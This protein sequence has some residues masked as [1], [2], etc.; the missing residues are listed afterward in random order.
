V[1]RVDL[2]RHGA[3]EASA[4]TGKTFAIEGLVI[5]LLVQEGVHLE[6]ILV[7]TY[8]EK[9]AGDLKSRLRARLETELENLPLHA[10]RLQDALDHF[11]HAHV[12]TIHGFCQ[13]T[14][15]E[16]AFEN[17]HD[18]R[19]QL[20]NDREL[21]EL[22]LR[23]IQRKE[24]QSEHGA[25]LGRVLELSG[26][27]AGKR[28]AQ[29][30]EELVLKLAGDFR[31][32]CDHEIAPAELDHWPDRL[33]QLENA[34]CRLWNELRRLAGPIDPRAIEEHLWYLGYSEL[35]FNVSWRES[36]R[37]DLLVPLLTWLG[38]AD[39][40]QN[41]LSTLEELLH[42]TD[43]FRKLVD[44]RN[45]FG[46]A[47]LPHKCPNLCEAVELIET[48]RSSSDWAT[49]RKQLHVA[50]VHLL[51][52][53]LAEYKHERGLQS[54]EDM[55]TKLDEA[56][57]PA[58][59]PHADE[60]VAGLR[61]RYRYGIVD[62]FQDTDPVQWRIFRRIFV[63]GADRQRLFVV[64][65]PKQA[66]FAF[67]GAD[68]EAYRVAHGELL[69]RGAQAQ[70]LEVNW[71]SCPE[72]I[73]PLN[74]LFSH[75]NW[76]TSSGIPYRKVKAAGAEAPF[77]LLQGQARRP[78]TLVELGRLRTLGQARREYARYVV[79]EI[80]RLLHPPLLEFERKKQRRVLQAGDICLLVFKRREA[81]P[82]VDA[83]RE[84]GISFTLYKQ[85]GLWQSTEATHLGYV[86]RAVAHPDDSAAFRAALLTRFF[87][88][89]PAEL[90]VAGELPPNH[91]IQELFQKW[92]GLA[93]A[94]A[95]AELFQSILEET[96]VLFRE[97]AGTD[98][99]RALANYRQLA[100][101]L[102]K[103]AYERDLDLLGIL[104]VF[105]NL[106][107]QRKE[108]EADLQPLESERP[109]VKIMT[110]HASKGLEFP[111]VFLAGGF[112]GAMAPQYYTYHD[113]HKKVVFDLRL[114]DDTAKQRYA[115]ERD[116]EN[117]RLLYV[118]LTRA[119]FRLYLPLVSMEKR[120]GSSRGPL[121]E[122]LAPAVQQAKL[123]E[124]AGVRKIIPRSLRRRPTITSVEAEPANHEAGPEEIVQV[125][126]DLFPTLDP[127]LSRRRILI[128]SFSSLH[129]QLAARHAAE[130]SYVERVPRADDDLRASIAT[131]EP[132]RGP[133][134]GDMVH[135][136][137]AE[138][139][140][141][142]VG[143]ALV[144]EAL[145]TSDSP[146]RALI[147]R[148]VQKHVARLFTRLKEEQ[149]LQACREQ[150]ARFIWNGLHAR[151]EALGG[152]LHEI[153]GPDRL[154][155]LEFHFPAIAGTLPPP[156]IKHEDTFLTGFMD[157]VFRKNGRYYL[158][159][160]KTNFLPAGYG[161]EQVAQAMEECD[162]IRQ[163]RLYLQALARWLEKHAGGTLAGVYYL[164]LRGMNGR[165]ESSGVYFHQPVAE[166]FQLQA[167]G[168]RDSQ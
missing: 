117:R 21:M 82:L 112:T 141:G 88:I 152:P 77:K 133:A 118:A 85:Q 130:P 22:C 31:P 164:F 10:A 140:F 18:F 17:Q 131:D 33:T 32:A 93:E 120:Y 143:K 79:Q 154:H 104:E 139:D 59:N 149:L 97:P 108:E 168:I 66:I 83:L 146:T 68:V 124:S 1:Q 69:K 20:V 121:V 135:D 23:E 105:R 53:R 11:D 123:V 15:Q 42:G 102:K 45:K 6:Q 132:L 47:E 125:T 67:R 99:D 56:L 101:T 64:G 51:H 115:H 57:D 14:L 29:N 62:E 96:G 91:G 36:R 76:F 126:P 114:D 39:V 65:D 80:Q 13:R 153:A 41:P 163:Y 30:W 71:R 72:L 165:D 156:D 26:F 34:A 167:I 4:G 138:I 94:R 5:D 157:L 52:Q 98:R 84:A 25:N 145:V 49:L 2:T 116:C 24:W 127:N 100:E 73:A 55:L 60:L 134:F 27:N 110:I 90:S 54:F 89:R 109:R 44:L 106:R 8:T 111:V 75:G 155:E 129:R 142:A 136:V 151:L 86:L 147:D 119:C 158:V 92:Y 61:E 113:D 137:I 37:R 43:G 19:S 107:N 16:F 38:N 144:P 70:D 50:T 148:V 40:E 150:V 46:L 35:T 74:H 63:D 78:L 48:F 103:A 12:F 161:P 95:W 7:V 3:I 87:R 162:Y 159:D 9:A 28:G 81:E 160:W 122:I 166:D 128:R 58:R